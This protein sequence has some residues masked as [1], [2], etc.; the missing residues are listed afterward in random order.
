MSAQSPPHPFTQTTV[1]D[2]PDGAALKSSQA[3]PFVSPPPNESNRPTAELSP[4]APVGPPA[5]AGDDRSLEATTVVNEEP[6]GSPIQALELTVEQYAS[7]C[8]EC[9]VY[10]DR[11][12]E[13]QRR[14]HV[15]SEG[16]RRVIDKH[17]KERFTADA[18]LQRR[19]ETSFASYRAW[20]TVRK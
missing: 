12:E 5:T 17:W 6:S 3:L 2:E 18:D 16:A 15:P 11:A 14:Y 19:F 7:L 4:M 10:P 13:I 1:S 9:V 8:A 20:L